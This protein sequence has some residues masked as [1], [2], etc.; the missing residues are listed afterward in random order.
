MAIDD[1]NNDDLTLDLNVGNQEK[2]QADLNRAKGYAT[3]T[4]EAMSGAF[5]QGQVRADRFG[6]SML[7]LQKRTQ[8]LAQEFQKT[9]VKDF[10]N[11][12]E[13]VNVRARENVTKLAE[14]QRTLKSIDEQI[15]GRDLSKNQF[16]RLTES[17]RTNIAELEREL[18]LLRQ[19]QTLQAQSIDPRRTSPITEADTEGKSL[20]TLQSN[21]RSLEAQFSRIRD[22]N[23]GKGVNALKSEATAAIERIQEL[24]S[25][26][27][28]LDKAL[29]GETDKTVVAQIVKDA[30]QAEI[31][32]AV[33]KRELIGLQLR[34]PNVPRAG[35][36]S[37]ALQ[38]F[39]P[40]ARGLGLPDA[41][42]GIGGALA[43]GVAVAGIYKGVEAANAAIDRNR[44]LLQSQRA[45]QASASEMGVSYGFLAKK[46]KE[47]ADAAGLSI[48][49]TAELTQKVAQLVARTAQP[50][51]LDQTVKGLLDL[52]AA[53]GLDAAELT[54]VTNQIITGQDE[55]YKKLG[56]KNPQILYKEYAEKQSRS[57]ESL[58]Q[59]ERQRIYQDEILKKA[60]LFS[61][62][63]K[64]RLES[65][66][67]QIAKT[68]AA[69]ENMLNSLSESF[70][71]SRG[72]FDF[73]NGLNESLQQLGLTADQTKE[74]LSQGISPAEL[75]KQGSESGI[76]NILSGIG[77]VAGIVPSELARLQGD[78]IGAAGGGDFL[79][80]RADISFAGIGRQLFGNASSDYEQELIRRNNAFLRI[81][82]Q[83][84]KV[85]EEQ[86]KRLEE[87]DREEDIR[88]Q[89]SIAD[90]AFERV[91]KRKKNDVGAID[92]AYKELL[93]KSKLD[94]TGIFF[95]KEKLESEAY[96]YAEAVS[97]A[98]SKS[99][100]TIV[101]NPNAKL[102]DL[103]RGL[104]GIG[105]EDKLTD[106]DK[107]RL[108]YQF[109]ASIKS[110][111]ERIQSLTKQVRDTSVQIQGK[112]NPFVKLFSDI[113]TAADRA[114]ERFGA[115]GKDFVDYMAKME[116]AQLKVELGQ[117]RFLYSL[118]ALDYEQQAIALKGISYQQTGGFQ[119]NLQF[120]GASAE[121]VNSQRTL[122]NQAEL[123]KFYATQFDPSGRFN[124]ANQYGPG[125]YLEA[126]LGASG[127]D[128]LSRDYEGGVSRE[129]YVQT[130]LQIQELK[131]DLQ[132]FKQID[133]SGLGIL[134]QEA[135]AKA[136]EARI[137]ANDELFSR[138]N[139]YGQTKED[140]RSL[141]QLRSRDANIFRDANAERFDELVRTQVVAE[142]TRKFAQQKIDLLNKSG[143]SQE[144][145]VFAAQQALSIT[146]ELG[147]GELTASLRSSRL[148]ALNVLAEDAKNKEKDA[149]ERM[150]AIK[151]ALDSVV[152]A[153]TKTG[154][155]ID[156]ASKPIL[157]VNINNQT[158]LASTSYRPNQNDVQKR[159]Q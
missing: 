50:G 102:V 86:K 138:L 19:L 125:G 143:V 97:N 156:T 158:G 58:S 89:G 111:V 15:V 31:Q 90:L 3:E 146:G 115:F 42:Y 69:W 130:E 63:A 144:D 65:V 38:A 36:E 54:T 113:D 145:K 71:N 35:P 9:S 57:V 151:V 114:Q 104:S 8:V 49:K 95:N 152:T 56:I 51:R 129:K 5:E 135:I 149:T 127:L 157:D 47:Y 137:P 141:L 48:V 147:P 93:E 60:A 41:R 126:K 136:I 123:A 67:G 27:L 76:Y 131:V 18:I 142:Q 118:K 81:E 159:G 154:V 148:Q 110:T 12:L 106:E 117:T 79:K 139:S 105:R 100:E 40:I 134:G 52:G 25:K 20:L 16:D 99:F 132:K 61:G 6:Q 44:E 2:W 96:K 22:I 33:L 150:K 92:A 21:L 1:I 32:I 55:A 88:R 75:A 116:Q 28:S 72:V 39:T 119:R 85:A 94:I 53:R 7:T 46:N 11:D 109:E 64:D 14:L 30:R 37:S 4:A 101:K 10:G 13:Y 120:A 122:A 87:Q 73:I 26:V 59:L 107:E 133:T 74:K 17:V 43:I 45:L 121:F 128:R 112:D 155:K 34:A 23:V 91:L 66:D 124:N 153:L 70:A 62:A 80:K 108:T 140:A 84:K 98:V 29:I 77:A 83:Q 24:R 82:A 68:S 103:Q 78:A